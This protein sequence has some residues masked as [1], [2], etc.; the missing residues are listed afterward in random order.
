M[1]SG[2]AVGVADRP[3]QADAGARDDDVIACVAWRGGRVM[4]HRDDG[5]GGDAR[6]TSWIARAAGVVSPFRPLAVLTVRD[7]AC[8]GATRAG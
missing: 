5:R 4:A 3:A 6:V 2:A 8:L 7:L 1:L